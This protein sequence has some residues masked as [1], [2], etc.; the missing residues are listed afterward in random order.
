[1]TK[2]DGVN[3]A[4]RH[5][6]ANDLAYLAACGERGQEQFHIFHAGGDGC[7]Q[8]NRRKYRNR[9]NLRGGSTFR[10]SA[11][12]AGS[13]QLPL[14]CFSASRD[15]WDDTKLLPE[16]RDGTNDRRLGHFPAQ[17]LFQMRYIGVPGFKL[18]V[19]MDGELRNLS[20]S[21]QLRAATP[22]AISAKR[23]DIRK[24]PCC[25]HEIGLLAGL[26][27]QI[28]PNRNSIIFKPDKQIFGM[29][30]GLLFGGHFG[31]SSD[32]FDE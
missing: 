29:S 2:G 8:V 13:E 27:Q 3:L 17:S 31:P 7:L 24:N 11:L 18:L 5:Q 16:L 25:H 23:I 32:G 14:G 20:R 6:T 22:V 21:G 12:E 30:D 4:G 15:H 26:A 1:M 28:E 9:C 19:D 10:N